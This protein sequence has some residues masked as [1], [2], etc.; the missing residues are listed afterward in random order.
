MAAN[1]AANSIGADPLATASE[2]R[3][4]L[5]REEMLASL[6]QRFQEHPK[7]RDYQFQSVRRHH[8]R[9]S[10]IFE[11][12]HRGK[13]SQAPILVKWRARYK[14]EDAARIVEREYAGLSNLRKRAGSSLDGTIPLPLARY[15]ELGAIVTEKLPGR[16]LGEI[17]KREANFFLGPWRQ[18]RLCRI[19]GNAG[20]WLRTFHD[21]TRSE[22]QFHDSDAFLGE[23]EN[24]LDECSSGG[25]E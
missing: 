1:V 16:D 13:S 14:S 8:A 22:P 24:L 20:R 21:L 18:K 6:G 9:S 7:F 10:E 17:L 5:R 19:A 4:P 23:V 12:K 15:H 2:G 11:F 3:G 25:M